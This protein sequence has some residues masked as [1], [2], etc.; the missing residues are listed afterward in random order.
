[1]SYTLKEALEILQKKGFLYKGKTITARTMRTMIDNKKFKT[2]HKCE[3]G[4][5]NLI[6]KIEIDEKV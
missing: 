1:M 5:C 4:N 6:S 3:A 2:A